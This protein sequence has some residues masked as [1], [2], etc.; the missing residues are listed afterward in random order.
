MSDHNTPAAEKLQ[1]RSAIPPC[2]ASLV[3]YTLNMNEQQTFSSISL[4]GKVALVT[5]G[6]RGIGASVALQLA[7]C[8]ANVAINYRS[9]KSRAQKIAQQ[10]A[11]AGKETLLLQADITNHVEVRAMF[12]TIQSTWGKLDTLVLNASGGL[13]RDRSNDYAMMLNRD[14]QL[15]LVRE[16]VHI[17]PAGGCIVFVTSHLAHFHGTK[18][19]Y[20]EY[21]PV[22][23]SKKAGEDALREMIPELSELGIRL[24]VVS[25]D[26]IEGTITP[27]LLQRQ[28][29][30]LIEQRRIEAGSLPSVEEFAAAIV[31]SAIRTDYASGET[32]FVGSTE[33]T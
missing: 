21:E 25:G 28:S 12:Q 15:G 3:A 22:A 10:I 6:S 1:P 16:A 14:A 33:W 2:S 9:K 13:E 32:I 23:A 5:G 8:G 18:N 11:A 29:P 30:G 19:V 24:V 20:Q 7:Q 17:L 4:S 26:L 31:R 27:K